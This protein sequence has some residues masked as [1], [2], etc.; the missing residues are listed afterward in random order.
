MNDFQKEHDLV[1]KAIELNNSEKFDVLTNVGTEKYFIGSVFPDIIINEKG[2]GKTIFIIEVKRNGG[3]ADCIQKWKNQA[4]IP[5]QLFLVV[6]DGGSDLA[7]AKKIAEIV[8]LPLRF[9][10]YKII[11]ERAHV[12]YQPIN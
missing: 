8:S 11:G 10:T 12:Q 7:N 6:P 3:I 4:F 5:G 1:V 2:T 9:G